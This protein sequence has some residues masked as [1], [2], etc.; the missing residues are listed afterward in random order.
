VLESNRLS[1]MQK[2]HDQFASDHSKMNKTIKLLRRNHR[3]SEM[4]R[5]VKQYIR[6]CH[7]SRRFKTARDK[8]NELLNSLSMF[9][10]SWTNITLDFVTKLFDSRDYN[11]ILMIVNKLSKMHHY[12]FCT[13][14]EN[15][16]TIEKIVKL[17]IQHVWKLHELFTTMISNRDSQ[18]I[19]FIWDTICKM[20]RIKT[21]LF[22]AFHSETN[23]QSE[24]FNQK[25][26]CYL[27]VYV[28]HQQNDWVDW[29][30]MIK[31]AFNAFISVITQ[32]FSFLANYEFESR[33]SFDQIE[34]DENTIRKQ[35]TRIKNKKI[36]FIMKSI[37][38]FAKEHMKKSQMN[39]VKHANRHRIIAS[40]YQ[41]EDR[42]W[43]FNKNIQIDRS[44]KKL[45]H[46]M[47]KSFKIRKK[48]KSSYKLDLSDDINLHSVFHTSLLKKNL[49]DFLFKQIISS[50]SSIMIDDEQ[51][52]DV[53]NI[54]DSRLTNRSINKRLQY[55]IKWVR[56]SSNRKWYSIENFENAKEIVT[57]YHQRYF[58]RSKSHFLIIQSLFISL[59]TH[60]INS[61]SWAQKS[62]Q[63][64]K[65]LIENIL[66]Q[67]KQKM[68]FNIIKQTSIFNVERNNIKTKTINQD[69]FVIKIISVE[70]ILS[71]QN[72]EKVM[73]RFRVNLLIR[74]SE[75]RNAF[76]I[77]KINKRE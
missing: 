70:R 32:M 7:I 9:D 69:C 2:M 12:I 52:F 73:S 64:T 55:K 54:I 13:I 37:W 42:V 26:K 50:S 22:I 56:H 21:K 68:K 58:D 62:I 24:I 17:L 19:S 45:N 47:L 67:M 15:E 5:D 41:I 76:N 11:A 14:D 60:L 46:K 59:M 36:V 44:S 28:N 38:K 49:E 53:E 72:K 31:Y 18:F 61:F 16:I 23:E 35:I 51:K 66:N 20:L 71:N 39:Q 33:M 43:L 77:K 75:S 27:R 57:N 29:L 6:N 65:N 8:Y 48:R 63:K 25:M 40:D 34:F 74:W 1:L 30:F 3:W 10:R 4:I